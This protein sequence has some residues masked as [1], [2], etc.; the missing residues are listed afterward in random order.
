MAKT[1]RSE[2][3]SH[4]PAALSG[5]KLLWLLI[6]HRPVG[7]GGFRLVGCCGA[8]GSVWAINT[9]PQAYQEGP[10]PSA[11]SYHPVNLDTGMVGVSLLHTNC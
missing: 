7:G 4:L 9:G 8:E 3:L 11:Y 5:G 2:F 1:I 10:G 6:L